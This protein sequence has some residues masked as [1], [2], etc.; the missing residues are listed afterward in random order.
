MAAKRRQEDEWRRA[1]IALH[2]RGYAVLPAVMPDSGWLAL[3]AEAGRLFAGDAF[4]L[5]RIGRG[6][7]VRTAGSTRGGS[8]CWL[9]AS[10]PAA[11]V[12]MRSMETLR[13]SLNRDLFLG[14][15]SFEAHYA[16][17]PVGAG[18]E[19]HVDR[20][21][22]STARVVSAVIY[23]NADWPKDGGGELVLYDS[24]NLPRLVLAP[25]GGTLILFMSD[26]TPHEVRKATRERWS[27]AGWFRT[28][29]TG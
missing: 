3:R 10:M 19:T 15:D 23:L 20:H 8:L 26:G 11:A 25:G 12:F 24:G 4:S 21:L 14:L 13:L 28:R 17:Y 9:D 22:G 1:G 29:P 16:H 5:A 2:A 7:G 27:I 6:D 18:Y